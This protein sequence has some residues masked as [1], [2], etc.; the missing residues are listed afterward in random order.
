MKW[1]LDD[2]ARFLLERAQLDRLTKEVDWLSIAWK[3]SP[4][5][6]VQVDI[7]LTVHG[8]TYAGQLIYP[9]LFPY[10]PP[11]IRPRDNAERWTQ[12]Q[13]GAGG[14]LCLQWRADN[15]QTHVSGAD[16]VRSAYEL[17][18]TEQHPSHPGV[19][20]S[21]HRVTEG[22][23]M[24]SENFRF[25]ATSE[26]ISSL[27]GLAE[28]SRSTLKSLTILHLSAIITSISSI[29]TS[30]SGVVEITDMPSGFARNIPL[31]TYPGLGLIFRSENF[32]ARS[33]ISSA[34]ELLET[35]STA[36]FE[37]SDLW[38]REEATNKY[39]EK[40]VV[41]LG[42]DIESIRIFEIGNDEQQVLREFKIIHPSSTQSRHPQEH[43]M[44][45]DVRIGIVGL[46]SIGSKVAVS[47][48]RSGARRFLLVDDDFLKPENLARNEL[49]W[50]TVGIHKVEAVREEL[51]FIASG[52]SVDVRTSRVAGQESGL[53][54]N[55]TLNDLATCDLLI[56]A[57]ANP[58]VFLN[59]AAIAKLN[60]KPL[61]WGEVFAGGYGG[62]IA[63]ARPDLDPNPLV[64]RSSI[65]AYYSTLPTAPFQDAQGY[66]IDHEIPLMAYDS[67]VS[68]IAA[69]LTRLALDTAL[70]RNPSIFPYPAYLIGM[71]KEWDFEQPFDTRPIEAKGDGWENTA[72]P[73]NN[74]D[75][76]VVLKS[77]FEMITQ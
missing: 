77:L 23:M 27:M 7:D 8:R 71:A 44:L 5:M 17:L 15:W 38:V 40:L 11:Y 52:I 60:H 31:V 41:I 65:Y 67:D 21:A 39:I 19:V 73:V 46:G 3:I 68:L 16:M 43:Q 14:S 55:A 58:E 51:S 56:D 22:Q 75:Q 54:N 42:S 45:S 2:P 49:N 25:V 48:A 6:V 59:L 72:T 70:S 69:S 20:P 62:L 50:T 26:L 33:K 1:V 12:H 29:T 9:E 74:L 37:T 18:S 34:V 35:L 28:N 63:R 24:R 13:Y 53:S 4:E 47:L 61:C 57:S 32:S 10:A 64:V 36:G 30:S 76:Q 66:D